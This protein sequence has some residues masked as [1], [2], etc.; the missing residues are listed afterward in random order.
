[1]SRFSGNFLLLIDTLLLQNTI[2]MEKKILLIGCFLWIIS[3]IFCIRSCLQITTYLSHSCFYQSAGAHVRSLMS[4]WTHALCFLGSCNWHLKQSP[5]PLVTHHRAFFQH[6]SHSSFSF[7]L[8]Q[9]EH[10]TV[11]HHLLPFLCKV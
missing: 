2:I 11:Q 8:S 10:K 7:C 5:G 1:M 6:K 9:Y 4:A 3:G